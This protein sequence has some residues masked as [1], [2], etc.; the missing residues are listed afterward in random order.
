M[1]RLTDR[2]EINYSY[3]PLTG[4]LGTITEALGQV[5]TQS[6]FLDGKLQGSVWT[7]L[8]AGTAATPNVG[9]TYD[10]VYGRLA[11]MTDGTGSTIFSYHPVDGS[12]FGAGS[13]KRPTKRLYS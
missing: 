10:A 13:R 8:A 2:N 3:Q 12:T 9:F 1:R 4:W 5:K 7:N 6:Y 11:T